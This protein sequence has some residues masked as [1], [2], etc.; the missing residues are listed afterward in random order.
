MDDKKE[1]QMD[2]DELVQEALDEHVSNP[3]NSSRA[4]QNEGREEAPTWPETKA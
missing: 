1:E 2:L 4:E 3:A